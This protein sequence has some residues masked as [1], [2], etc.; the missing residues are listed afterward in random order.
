VDVDAR[1]EDTFPEIFTVADRKALNEQRRYFRLTAAGLAAAV[2]AAVGSAISARFTVAGHRL[3]AGGMI[4][5]VAF[6]VGLGVAGY[7]LVNKPERAWYECRAAAES[8]KTLAWQ[9]CVR[10]GSFDHD[11]P[12]DARHFGRLVRRIVRGLRHAGLPTVGGSEEVTGAMSAF[13]GHPLATRRDFY[14]R[15]RILDQNRYYA[16]KAE[17]NNG[18]AQRWFLVAIV[19]QAAGV[20]LAVLKALDTV[21]ADLLGIAATAA[22][23]ALAWVQTKDSQALAESYVV[24][25]NELAAI[26]G[27][28][29]EHPDDLAEAEWSAFVRS[30]EQAIS[31]EHTL[32]LARRDPGLAPED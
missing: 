22:A 18:R 24:A 27:E 5:A 6:L 32:W 7:V 11:T 21:D 14:L 25:A 30:G 23:S 28:A 17:E 20:V 13:R 8:I 10:G 15:Q 4:S 29:A 1:V 31:R 12:T 16:R 3:E 9:Y 19:L 26:R 2:V